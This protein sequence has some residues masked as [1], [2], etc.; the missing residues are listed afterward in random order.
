V[1]LIVSAV[2]ERLKKDKKAGMR[3]GGAGQAQDQDFDEVE[4]Q[5]QLIQN[6][7]A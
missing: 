3:L 4:N 7:L 2:N 5:R 6:G 1:E